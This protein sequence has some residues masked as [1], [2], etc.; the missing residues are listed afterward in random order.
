MV[1][2]EISKEEFDSCVSNNVLKNYYQTSIY[3]DLMK[4]G[5]YTPLYIKATEGNKIV[6]ISLILSKY[7]TIKVKYGYAPRGFLLNY[8]DFDLLKDFTLS[9]KKFLS[10]R[11][12]AFL[13]INPEIVLSQVENSTGRKTYNNASVK[14]IKNMQSLN[15]KKLKDNI[16]FESILPKYN[17]IINLDTFTF[18]SLNKNIKQKVKHKDEKGFTLVKGDEYT[19]NEFYELVKNKNNNTLEFYK[20]YYKYFNKNKMVDIWFIQVDYNKYLEVLKEEY[21]ILEQ[22]SEKANDNFRHNTNNKSLLNKKM[23]SDK[24]ITTLHEYISEINDLLKKEIN[25]QILATAL[26]IKFNN[27]VTIVMSGYDKGKSKFNANHLLYLKLIE[28]YKNEGYKFMD[29][30]G[31]SGDFSKTNPYHGL[32]EFKLN[33]NPIIYEYIGEFDLII[34]DTIYSLLWSA[35]KLHNEFDKNNVVN[36]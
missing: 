20:N 11:D 6:G 10:K 17:P 23:E 22:E 2:K 32:N 18:L 34:K 19:L 30:N 16:Y 33:F 4:K 7:I 35:K 21:S 9:L 27:R 29:L 8:Y 15:Y 1:I 26:V 25:S 24:S 3:G 36:T 14:L 12:F 31:I 13:K 28:K 5:G